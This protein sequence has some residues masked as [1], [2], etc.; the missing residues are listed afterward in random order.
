MSNRIDYGQVA[1]KLDYPTVEKKLKQLAERK[2]TRKRKTAAD[3]LEP[4]REQLLALHRKGWSSSQLVAE[5]K[6]SGVPVSPARFR[7]CLSRWA[8]N[9]KSRTTRR[10]QSSSNTA[11]PAAPASQDTRSKSASAAGQT[12]FKLTQP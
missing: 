9:G 4:L 1:E 12:G 11:Q 5:L 8:G 7:E 2:P 6:N 3:V 10:K